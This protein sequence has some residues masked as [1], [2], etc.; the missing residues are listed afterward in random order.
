M[1]K[2]L[3]GIGCDGHYVQWVSYDGQANQKREEQDPNQ[4]AHLLL[5]L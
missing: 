3:P 1:F 2:D 5:V 4:T